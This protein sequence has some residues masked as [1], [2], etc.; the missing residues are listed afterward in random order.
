MT[1]IGL[2]ALSRLCVQILEHYQRTPGDAG[3]VLSG[4]V[5]FLASGPRIRHVYVNRSRSSRAHALAFRAHVSCVHDPQ[6]EIY[7]KTPYALRLYSISNQYSCTIHICT[8]RVLGSL[9]ESIV[10]S[11]MH[12]CMQVGPAQRHP[13]S[14]HSPCVVLRS[15][16]AHASCN[17]KHVCVPIARSTHQHPSAVPLV[18][19]WLSHASSCVASMNP[20]HAAVCARSVQ[21]RSIQS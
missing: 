7:Q 4:W 20:V 9:H 8:G 1:L 18:G 16:W 14:L 12:A 10:A 6:R 17:S 5:R 21:P 11:L 19:A 15:R 3:R 2:L 13:P